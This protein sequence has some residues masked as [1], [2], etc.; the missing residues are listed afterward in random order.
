[1][2][3][4]LF[5]LAPGAFGNQHK[6]NLGLIKSMLAR[7]MESPVTEVQDLAAKGVCSFVLLH[8]TEDSI[9]KAFQDLLPGILKV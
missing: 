7:C 2:N 9:Q 4:F 3:V 5:S 6:H 8:D 1:M